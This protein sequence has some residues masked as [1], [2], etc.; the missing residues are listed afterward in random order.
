[1]GY[2]MKLMEKVY[3]M[4][5]FIDIWSLRQFITS[6]ELECIVDLV[7]IKVADPFQLYCN[8]QQHVL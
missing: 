3:I 1:M 4:N 2:H 7:A 6:E 5:D 8:H